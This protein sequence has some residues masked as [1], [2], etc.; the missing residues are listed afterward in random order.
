VINGWEDLKEI[1]TSNFQGM[2]VWPS[3]PRDLK[4]CWQKLGE[5]LRDYIRRFFWKYHELLRVDD[6]DVILTFWSGTI[7]QTLVHEL[8]LDQPNATK[9]LLNIAIWHASSEEAV[10]VVFVLGN[11][12]TVPGGGRAASSKATGKGAKK[13]VR[14]GKKGQNLCPALGTRQASPP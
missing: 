2:N 10:E 12:K 1:F 13:G 3:N 5:S 6:A 14:G 11:G 9:E 4:S 8:D 7:H